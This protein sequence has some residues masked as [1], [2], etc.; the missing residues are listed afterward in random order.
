MEEER[1]THTHTHT[2]THIDQ[3]VFDL[4]EQI[5]LFLPDNSVSI[6][7]FTTWA[8]PTFKQYWLQRITIA[9]RGGSAVMALRN[10]NARLRGDDA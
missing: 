4:I 3:S 7:E 8:A 5:S 6:P 10:W 1:D 9:L 2:H